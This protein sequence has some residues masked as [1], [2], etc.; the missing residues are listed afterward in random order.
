[1]FYNVIQ[2]SSLK[3]K[4]IIN[5]SYFL[6][7]IVIQGEGGSSLAKLTISR[8]LKIATI[9]LTSEKFKNF[10]SR[11]SNNIMIGD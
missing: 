8:I 3:L 1:M 5:I 6:L 9:K 7:I 10:I 2:Y 11:S 4:K